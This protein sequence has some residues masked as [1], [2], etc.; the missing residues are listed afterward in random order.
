MKTIGTTPLGTGSLPLIKRSL[1]DCRRLLAKSEIVRIRDWKVQAQ[2]L[3]QK[4]KYK[5]FKSFALYAETKLREIGV[6]ESL[7]GDRETDPHRRSI[8]VYFQV[9]LI[10]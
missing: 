10:A 2:E 1:I 3:M 6:I 4:S 5:S 9:M 7:Q 8:A